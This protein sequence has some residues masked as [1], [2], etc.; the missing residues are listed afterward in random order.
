MHTEVMTLSFESKGF[1]YPPFEYSVERELAV[2]KSDDKRRLLRFPQ[3]F[4]LLYMPHL[5]ISSG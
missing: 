2:Q 5:Q 1:I 3:S 4:L